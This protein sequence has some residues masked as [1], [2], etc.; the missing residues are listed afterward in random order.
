MGCKSLHNNFCKNDAMT[1]EELIFT[2]DYNVKSMEFACA[3]DNCFKA[4]F[5]DENGET[6]DFT[7]SRQKV[8]EHIERFNAHPERYIANKGLCVAHFHRMAINWYKKTHLSKWA[9]ELVNNN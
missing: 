2:I 7:A 6:F 4:H 5:V 3:D 8:L 9:R 1:K